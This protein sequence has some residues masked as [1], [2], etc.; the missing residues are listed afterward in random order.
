MTWKCSNL[1]IIGTGHVKDNVVCQDYSISQTTDD[2]TYLIISDGAGSVK[3][4][5][6]GAKLAC[7]T[8][9]SLFTSSF[10]DFFIS[11]ETKIY[12]SIQTA[13]LDSLGSYIIEH[14]LNATV[15]D[16][17]STLVGVFISKERY[18]TIHIG[19]GI[20]GMVKEGNLE[21]ISPPRNG[22][23]ANETFFTTSPDCF[24]GFHIAKGIIDTLDISFFS[25]TDGTSSSFYQ[26][27]KL[28]SQRMIKQLSSLSV[29]LPNE[30]FN[31]FLEKV[32]QEKVKQYTHD[33]CSFGFVSCESCTS[34]SRIFGQKDLSENDFLLLVQYLKRSATGFSKD[35][36]PAE[37]EVLVQMLIEAGLLDENNQESYINVWSEG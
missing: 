32:I 8:V 4:A 30:L 31:R 34:F 18:I 22:E 14:S 20:I 13:V 15:H 3:Y 6:I 27:G 37:E 7:E 26:N 19:D 28:I 29:L 10:D 1:S 5:D 36:I 33:D 2:L 25:M 11:L 23:F 16:F 12:S 35:S 17:S 21:V 24:C 9:L